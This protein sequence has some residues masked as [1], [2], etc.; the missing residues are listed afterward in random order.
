MNMNITKAI[1]FATIKHQYQTR[2]GTSIPYIV[3]PFETALLLAQ[4][5]YSE[6]VVISALLHDTIEDT[7]TTKED[8]EAEFGSRV[9]ELVLFNTEEKKDSWEDRKQHTIDT[10]FIETDLEKIV[11]VLADKIANLRTMIQGAQTNPQ[12]LWSFFKRP[13]ES[14]KWYYTKILH[15][16]Q[17]FNEIAL[18]VEYQRLVTIVFGE[19][20]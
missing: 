12:Q 20:F 15:A 4:N 6:E 19:V 10:L 13:F 14:Q 5:G 3:H 8:I 11:L 7:P 9:A 17:R 1:E 2:K 18:Y 16:L